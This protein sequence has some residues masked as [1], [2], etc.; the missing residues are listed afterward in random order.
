MKRAMYRTIG[1]VLMFFACITV[2]ACATVQQNP[3]DR[4]LERVVEREIS[5]GSAYSRGGVIVSVNDGVAILKGSVKQGIDKILIEKIVR[6][7]EGISEVRN[8]IFVD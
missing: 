8:Y 2:S 3:E 7:I 6:D 1:Y 4:E 5:S